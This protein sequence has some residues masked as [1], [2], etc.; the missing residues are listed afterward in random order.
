[1][2]EFGENLAQQLPLD[3]F[4]SHISAKIGIVQ[5]NPKLCNDDLLEA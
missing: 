3:V 4:R 1:M 2:F 5:W